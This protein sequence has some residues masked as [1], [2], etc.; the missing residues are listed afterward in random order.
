MAANDRSIPTTSW[1]NPTTCP[2]CGETIRDPGVGFVE[3]IDESRACNEAFET[4]RDRVASDMGGEWS[5]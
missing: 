2:F 4:W 3:H 1:E 5:G